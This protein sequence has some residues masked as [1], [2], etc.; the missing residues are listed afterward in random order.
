MCCSIASDTFCEDKE[1]NHRDRGEVA[2]DSA[3]SAIGVVAIDS[4]LSAVGV[5]DFALSAVRGG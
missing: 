2:I 4:A 1:Y 5:I 3:P